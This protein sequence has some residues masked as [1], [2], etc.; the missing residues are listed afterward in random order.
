MQDTRRHRARNYATFYYAYMRCA[1]AFKQLPVLLPSE[2]TATR[3]QSVW[4]LLP[5]LIFLIA[6]IAT[7]QNL[8][9]LV[10]GSAIAPL[11]WDLTK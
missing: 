10:P 2:R 6:A 4:T 1:F 11:T 8:G 7:T 3:R 5:V 9:P